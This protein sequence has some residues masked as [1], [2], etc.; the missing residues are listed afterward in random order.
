MCLRYSVGVRGLQFGDLLLLT[1]SGDF[2]LIL[3]QGILMFW[4]ILYSFGGFSVL[5]K[6]DF[7]NVSSKLYSSTF[8][9]RASVVRR[10]PSVV[11]GF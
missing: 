4:G 1:F 2:A 10:G 8:L 7:D 6:K 9:V 3:F 11:R 5:L